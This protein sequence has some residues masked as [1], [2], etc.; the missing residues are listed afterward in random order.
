MTITKGA[1]GAITLFVCGALAL[2][3][4]PASAHHGR[5][6]L[7][8][9]TDDMPARGEAYGVLSLDTVRDKDGEHSTE[10]TPGVVLRAGSRIAIEPHFHVEREAGEDFK[11]AAAAVGV[12]Y[13]LGDLGHSGWRGALG[14]ETEIPR[15][16]TDE[17]S[18]GTF[19]LVAARTLPKALVAANLIV[20][21][22]FTA[23]GEWDY[24]IGAGVLTPL[25]NGD[26][27]GIGVSFRCRCAMAWRFCRRIRIASPKIRRS[28]SAWAGSMRRASI[29][30]RCT[31][32]WCSVFKGVL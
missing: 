12:R 13:R 27:I 32:N 25:P 28:S 6:F 1:R 16:R 29:P 31:R 30:V 26:Q 3:S 17:P 21:H 11:Y 18:N 15:N 9:E 2:T 24:S 23:D 14:F 7:L 5:D 20:D 22:E 10:I 8:I 4:R 19:R